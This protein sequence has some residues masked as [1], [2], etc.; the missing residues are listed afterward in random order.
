M[1]NGV[2]LNRKP[3]ESTCLLYHVKIDHTRW[4]PVSC[5]HVC[6]NCILE[7][8]KPTTMMYYWNHAIKADYTFNNWLTNLADPCS[9]Q[10]SMLNHWSSVEYWISWIFCKHFTL[11]FIV[12]FLPECEGF[13]D[14]LAGLPWFP[15]P[16]S[17]LTDVH[18]ASGHEGKHQPWA[19][20][21]HRN[22][23]RSSPQR[24]PKQPRWVFC[25][26]PYQW[27]TFFWLTLYR[28][29]TFF[30]LTLYQW[31]TFFWLTLYKWVNSFDSPCISELHSFDSSC[32]R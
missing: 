20:Q 9:Y 4:L 28:W 5:L 15:G 7:V 13:H 25:D 2:L 24:P 32:K 3:L 27:V 17:T 23:T 31:V 30:W 29:V 19:R 21:E 11:S 1:P 12:G 22:G 18:A 8:H 14:R 16:V 6:W 10:L 26:T